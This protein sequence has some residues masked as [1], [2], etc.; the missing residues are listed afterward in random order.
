MADMHNSDE[1]IEMQDSHDSHDPPACKLLV[2]YGHDSF[3]RFKTLF[4][5]FEGKFKCKSDAVMIK[6]TS[7]MPELSDITN[8]NGLHVFEG[9]N[10]LHVR[11]NGEATLGSGKNATKR[12][13]T[14]VF[15]IEESTGDTS[16]TRRMADLCA[17]SNDRAPNNCIPKLEGTLDGRHPFGEVHVLCDSC[18]KVLAVCSMPGMDPYFAPILRDCKK[19]LHKNGRIDA[20]WRYFARTLFDLLMYMH[21]RGLVHGFLCPESFLISNNRVVL[22]DFG[23][24][25]E[26]ERRYEHRPGFSELAKKKKLG[27]VDKFIFP[28]TA[29]DYSNL[30]NAPALK[31]FGYG[32][33]NKYGMSGFR[34]PDENE[35]RMSPDIDMWAAG[36]LLMLLFFGDVG[37]TKDLIDYENKLHQAVT[38]HSLA[39]FSA[40]IQGETRHISTLNVVFERIMQH[41]LGESTRLFSEAED[42]I[43]RYY[44]MHYNTESI[45]EFINL[46][47]RLLHPDG[48]KRI[49]AKEGFLSG[50]CSNYIPD[51][52]DLL[53]ELLF[54]GVF[55]EGRTMPDGTRTNPCVLI[56]EIG[57]GMCTYSIFDLNDK[58]IALW[59]GG[60]REV[61]KASSANCSTNLSA[62]SLPTAYWNINGT[63]GDPR[64]NATLMLL[65]RLGA[66]G[67]LAA[68]SRRNPGDSEEG[69]VSVDRIKEKCVV[70]HEVECDTCIVAIPMR[71]NGF[72]ERFEELKWDYDWARVCGGDSYSA[73]GIEQMIKYY[74]KAMSDRVMNILVVNRNHGK[75][76]GYKDDE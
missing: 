67:S 76:L 62:H 14:F 1:I 46:A 75:K 21:Q 48:D 63:P 55:V 58:K 6:K 42:N 13:V 72:T 18:S 15:K 17:H 19:E 33:Q 8:W 38:G 11:V 7:G 5:A 52:F 50:F 60:E 24:H 3:K 9:G 28:G 65:A 61:Y 43:D 74:E 23:R 66:V 41:A 4:E 31:A 53:D 35:V 57:K 2:V 25:Q 39:R 30:R 45:L 37:T 51:S 10:H 40:Y 36:A 44:L 29:R 56:L 20:Q 16:I 12:K 22:C 47:F 68:S 54:R 73:A 27:P 26:T 34:T 59:Y 70:L 32:Y 71:S 69:N 64:V 49:S